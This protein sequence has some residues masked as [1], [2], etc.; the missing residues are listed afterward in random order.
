MVKSWSTALKERCDYYYTQLL[1]YLSE[2]IGRRAG[3]RLC[4]LEVIHRLCLAEV[5]RIMQL[6]KYNELCATSCKIHNALSKAC[7]IDFATCHVMLLEYSYFKFFHLR[8]KLI[9]EKRYYIF[10]DRLTFDR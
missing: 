7:H 1:G 5:Q 8:K 9:Y 3:N 4:K 10:N 6:L 2:E